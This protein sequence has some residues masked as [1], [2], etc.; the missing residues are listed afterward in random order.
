[1]G[2]LGKVVKGRAH[3]SGGVAW[4]RWRTLRV[5]VFNGGEAAPVMDDIDG[6]AL[7]CRGRRENVRG[8]PIWMERDHAVVL[9]DNGG[10]RWCSGRNQRGG[11]VSSGR[12]R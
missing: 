2:T 4:R 8:E 6:V 11:G 12:S 10:R 5:A 9:T 3:P 1:V 7:L